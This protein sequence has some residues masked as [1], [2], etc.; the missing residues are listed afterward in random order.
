MNSVR[1]GSCRQ[2]RTNTC[3]RAL[4]MLLYL[5]TFGS[6][7]R[8]YLFLLI[9]FAHINI[10]YLIFL[11]PFIRHFPPFSWQ[12]P[13]I[14]LTFS[15][16]PS[17]GLVYRAWLRLTPSRRSNNSLYSRSL[18]P[19]FLTLGPN[20]YA[21]GKTNTTV[22]LVFPASGSPSFPP[23]E[24]HPLSYKAPSHAKT[25]AP[26]PLRSNSLP[27]TPSSPPTPTFIALTLAIT[28]YALNMAP[29]QPLLHPHRS[30]PASIASW[31]NFTTLE[32]FAHPPFHRPHPFLE[33]PFPVLSGLVRVDG[34]GHRGLVRVPVIG[35]R[36]NMSCSNAPPS[37][38][39]AVASLEAVP[40]TLT[41]LARLMAEFLLAISNAPP[42][43]SY[44]P[45]PP[46]RTLLDW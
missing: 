38:H 25:V 31:P 6:F 29:L 40:L 16:T 36:H 44:A 15:G 3:R 4:R 23:T 21:I 24:N 5:I 37:L 11:T 34:V 17:S 33:H 32:R 20:S 27:V 10:P 35:T 18:P 12:I 14:T 13:C 8:T 41:S 26:S 1:I 28:P 42:T 9:F 30:P 46:D 2:S 19:L 22:P 45:C 39:H 7:S 43:V